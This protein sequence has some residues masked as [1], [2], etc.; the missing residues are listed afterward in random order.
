[1]HDDRNGIRTQEEC[2]ASWIDSQNTTENKAYVGTILE[3]RTP[4]LRSAEREPQH[5]I[6]DAQSY[7]A[8]GT[9]VRMSD[10]TLR[11]DQLYVLRNV[12][13]QVLSCIIGFRKTDRTYHAMSYLEALK[14]I[15]SEGIET[16]VL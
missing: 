16:I 9:I 11:D 12:Y 6:T 4:D 10:L 7:N 13:R 2:A 15:E 5:K 8:G 3:N 14:K 1:M